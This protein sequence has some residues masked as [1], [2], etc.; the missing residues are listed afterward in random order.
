MN[1]SEPVE[2]VCE[3]VETVSEP[4][5]TVSEPVETVSEPVET[6][7]EPTILS[8]GTPVIDDIA[9]VFPSPP[10]LQRSRP[11]RT[12]DWNDDTDSDDE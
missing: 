12:W 5:E 2:T 7:S 8:L 3:P 4:V 6:V 11:R 1:Q 9:D 10:K